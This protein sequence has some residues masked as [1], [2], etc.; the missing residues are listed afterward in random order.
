MW[1]CRRASQPARQR[2]EL[3]LVMPCMPHSTAQHAVPHERQPPPKTHTLHL[4]M[5]TSRGRM[6]ACSGRMLL[7]MRLMQYAASASAAAGR[8]SLRGHGTAGQD[9]TP[10]RGGMHRRSVLQHAVRM[11]AHAQGAGCA[12]RGRA[13]SNMRCGAVPCRT[14]CVRQARAGTPWPVAS[15]EVLPVRACM[16][17]CAPASC[18]Q[19]RWRGR[20]AVPCAP[21]M[22]HSAS[23][24]PHEPH[25]RHPPATY[26][27]RVKSCS[28][29]SPSRFSGR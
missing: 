15:T 9:R 29:T 12:V 27:L 6:S 11:R 8:S 14:C 22:P 21:R 19:P 24:Q 20:C 1:A 4:S 18:W 5:D 7:P 10:V 23:S 13:V 3:W 2:C 16:H 25:K 28:L 26:L 17:A